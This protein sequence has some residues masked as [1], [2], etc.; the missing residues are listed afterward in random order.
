MDLDGGSLRDHTCRV[1]VTGA[2]GFVASHVVV[3]L[4]QQGAEV[5]AL[6]MHDVPA[7]ARALWADHS[8]HILQ[9][10]CDVRDRSAIKA[11]IR[12]LDPGAVVHAAA[13]TNAE[14]KAGFDRMYEVNV[15]GSEIVFSS[16][17]QARLVFVSSAAV[18]QASADNERIYTE[19][20]PAVVGASG[21][22]PST[23]YAATKRAAELLA[24][25]E[26]RRGSDFRVARVSAC[27][28]PAEHP[29]AGRHAMSIGYRAVEAVRAGHRLLAAGRDS[30]V[31]LTYVADIAK[32]VVAV[33]G[34]E[35]TSDITNVSAGRPM[36]LSELAQVVRG[37]QERRTGTDLSGSVY[38][39]SL[40]LGARHGVLDIGRLMSIGFV[41]EYT[42]EQS[43]SSYMDWLDEHEY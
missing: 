7:S 29:T 34:A 37:E 17:R 18:Y 35:D 33:L 23:D 9:V 24:L 11:V 32:G 27:F 43:V 15:L 26:R 39:L 19:T 42:L 38:E 2:A 31:D 1:L 14:G 6:D 3:Q 10:T 36:S 12:E 25:G 20:A 22:G 21:P 16:S 40:P 13:I 5:I 30:V 4:A 8:E 41:V 28:G